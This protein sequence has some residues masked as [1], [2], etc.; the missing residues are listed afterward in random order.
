MVRKVETH[1]S[2]FSSVYRYYIYADSAYYAEVMENSSRSE[3]ACIRFTI[4]LS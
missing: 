2:D 1:S 4:E 3:N